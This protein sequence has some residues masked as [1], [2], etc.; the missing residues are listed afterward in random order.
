[1]NQNQ[2]NNPTGREAFEAYVRSTTTFAEWPDK[3]GLL[4]RIENGTGPYY[5]A[6]AGD[7]WRCWQAAL[8]TKP[9]ADPAA[10][11]NAIRDAMLK[12]PEYAWGWH[13]NIAMA[14][15]DAGARSHYACNE[16]AAR[17]LGLL[18]P[19]VDTRKHPGFQ[20]QE[21]PKTLATDAPTA[22]QLAQ[23]G[24]MKLWV[25]SMLQLIHKKA[26]DARSQHS[27]K[28]HQCELRAAIDSIA[29]LS[30]ANMDSLAETGK[31][32]RTAEIARTAELERR[33]AEAQSAF[34]TTSELLLKS[35]AKLDFL[36]SKGLTVG[37]L[38]DGHGE[39][40]AYLIEP[41]SELCD[42]KT[43]RMLRK[44]EQERDDALTQL[45]K[46]SQAVA[47]TGFTES[48]GSTL[49][50]VHSICG[51][52]KDRVRLADK[53]VAELSAAQSKIAELE[54]DAEEARRAYQ[55]TFD[56]MEI[57]HDSY[58]EELRS[59]LSQ[60]L[61]IACKD[62]MPTKEDADADDRVLGRM[63]RGSVREIHWQNA[64]RDYVHW[65][66]I[67]PLPSSPPVTQAT[68][69]EP[70]HISEVKAAFAAGKRVQYRLKTENHMIYVW[71]DVASPGWLPFCE[72]RIHPDDA[73]PKWEPKPSTSPERVA[74]GPDAMF[75]AWFS[76]LQR[77]HPNINESHRNAAEAMW[78]V[79][80]SKEA[81]P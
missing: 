16:G 46:I 35:D 14:C 76:A 74:L 44:A 47:S 12:D 20:K 66:P 22:E 4:V 62:R 11:L 32:Y 15:H 9:Q 17:F 57:S 18:F 79:Q 51:L 24:Y 19:G 80:M 49:G 37:M 53:K 38:K 28:G 6:V 54:K 48:E 26:V 50:M 77:E 23:V 68:E 58:C 43:L 56:S 71:K 52:A 61:W 3:E 67:P 64:Q 60:S 65:M 41:E 8:S 69:S 27:V 5:F 75:E 29:D 36:K 72:Y 25:G 2:T 7:L 73:A 45:D 31:L 10:A 59:R 21:E 13:C 55:L 34:L 63:P 33:L 30:K 42:N 78:A 39:R 40:L 81:R 70:D 1:M